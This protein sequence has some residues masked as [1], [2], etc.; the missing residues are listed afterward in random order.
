MKQ[1]LKTVRLTLGFTQAAFASQLGITQTAYSMIENGYR[2][3][4]FKYVKLL[5]SAFHLSE[6][7]LVNGEGEMFASSPYEK[8]FSDIFASLCEEHQQF[9]LQTARELKRAEEKMNSA[10]EA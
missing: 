4:S 9:L 6:P 3:L 8:E 2:P 7:W 5:C 1:R 10:K